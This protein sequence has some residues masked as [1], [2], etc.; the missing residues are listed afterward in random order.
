MLRD[1]DRAKA[2]RAMAAMMKMKKMDVAALRKAY[3]G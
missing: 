3:N 2:G 1:A